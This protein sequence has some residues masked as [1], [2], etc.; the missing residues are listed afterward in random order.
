MAHL[1]RLPQRNL[2]SHKD[3]ARKISRHLSS[4]HILVVHQGNSNSN[5]RLVLLYSVVD[6]LLLL[7]NRFRGQ[8]GD[9]R[10]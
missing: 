4:R 8:E 3:Q 6:N 1:L 5:P 9:R 7:A 10:C 2:N